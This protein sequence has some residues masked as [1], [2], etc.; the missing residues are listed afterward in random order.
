MMHLDPFRLSL[1]FGPVAVY[2]VLLGAMNLARRP[3]LVS[4]MRDVTALGL[5][6]SGFVIVGP[7]TLFFPEAAAA[8]FGP[9]IWAF[10]FAL[11]ALCLVLVIL[12]LRPRLIIYNI[13]AD[14]L[15]PILAE[16]VDHIDPEARWAGDS[17]MLPGLGVQL[18]IENLAWMRNVS[19]VAAGP[20]QDYQGWRRLEQALAAALAHV[21][22]SPNARG[23]TLLSMGLM[24]GAALCYSIALDPQAVARAMFDM[25]QL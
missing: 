25:F 12:L 19:L 9:Y 6:I 1:A 5:A 22:V 4:G 13:P 11:Y 16:L 21:E 7:I 17:L 24:I 2:L 8:H 23:A 18:H 3:F 10:L 15:R 14:H 20:H